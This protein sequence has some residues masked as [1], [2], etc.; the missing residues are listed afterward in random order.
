MAQT[1]RKFVIRRS[2]NS[3]QVDASTAGE[4]GSGAGIATMQRFPTEEA[5]MGWAGEQFAIPDRAWKRRGD[6][7]LEATL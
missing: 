1:S 2:A 4:W 6:G 7:T 5:A 3:Y